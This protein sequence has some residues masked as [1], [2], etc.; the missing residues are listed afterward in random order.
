MLL[1]VSGFI[2][3]L[4]L[5]AV[6]VLLFCQGKKAAAPRGEDTHRRQLE[7]LGKLTGGLAHEIKNPLSTIK[8]NLKLITEEADTEDQKFA[9]QLRKINIVQKEADRLEHI[10]DDFLRY[11]G[12]PQLQLALTDV[13]DLLSSM[14]DF[15]MPQARSRSITIRLGLYKDPLI[16]KIDP[17]M[18]K[19]VILNLLIN[20][21][22]AMPDGGEMIIRTDMYNKNAT[23][24]VSDTGCGIEPEKLDRIFEAYYTSRPGGSGLGLP[25][26][27]KIVEAHNGSISVN[28]LPGKGTSFTISLSL[29][30][31]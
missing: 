22:Q 26:A 27:K 16:C 13:N 7:E 3:A 29:Q 28:S 1:F 10:L 6:M 8:I 9:R 19:Q 2:L 4:V 14:V 12:R 30:S 21:Q 5:V 11:I 24:E 31:D 18:I 23:M 20:A 25:T 15:Y 17:D